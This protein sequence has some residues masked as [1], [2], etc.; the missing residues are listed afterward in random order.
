[1]L[2]S[3][4]FPKILL[5]SRNEIIFSICCFSIIFISHGFSR[6]ILH[7]NDSKLHFMPFSNVNV[8]GNKVN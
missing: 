6:E 4:V 5:S 7:K 3:S 2:L 1:M 8:M